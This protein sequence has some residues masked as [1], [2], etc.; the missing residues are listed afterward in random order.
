MTGRW[1]SLAGGRWLIMEGGG[2]VAAVAVAGELTGAMLS[3]IWLDSSSLYPAGDRWLYPIYILSISYL[4]LTYLILSYPIYI[5]SITYPIL[6]YLI[7]SI[8]YLYP[9]Y[10]LSYPI[11]ILSYPIPSYD[12]LSYLLSYPILS[13]PI[14][15]LCMSLYGSIHLP[16]YHVLR[17]KPNN[18]GKQ[19]KG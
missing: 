7:L 14:F 9:N 5:L 11:Y 6:S 17:R 2:V 1:R 18:I 12:I 10:I 8:S 16:L 19:R 13:R 3:E 15:Y 4:I